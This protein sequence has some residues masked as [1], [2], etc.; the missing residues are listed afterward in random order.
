MKKILLFAAAMLAFAGCKEDTVTPEPEPD[1]IS[2]APE[3]KDFGSAGGKVSVV[4]TS[5]GEWTLETEDNA[6][7]NW[8]TADKPS[9]VDGDVVKFEVGRNTDADAGV[10]TAKFIFVCGEATA[11]FTITSTPE[12]IVVPELTIAVTSETPVE[13][14]YEAGKF[15]V[16]LAISE[17]I[18]YHDLQV[19]INQDGEWLSHVMTLD[20]DEDNTAKMDFSYA[21]LDGLDSREAEITISY[22]GAE[23][24]TVE[25]LQLPEPVLRVDKDRQVLEV[26]EGTFSVTVET[27]V[28]YA[29]TLSEG[30]EEW[31]KDQKNEG[32]VWS[33]SH[34]AWT[35]QGK[36]EA[37][38]TFTQTDVAEG[39]EPLVATVKVVQSNYIINVAAYMKMHCAGAPESGWVKPD[40][41]KF[42]D[43]TMTVEMLVNLDSVYD[44]E[45]GT[46]FGIERR[47][48]IRHGDFAPK[49]TWELVYVT[50]QTNYQGENQE[51]KLTGAA[52]PTDKWA[53]IAVV[54]DGT[55]KT[56]TLYQDGEQIAT[57]AMN[58]DIKTIDLTETYKNNQGT[59]QFYLGRAYDNSRDFCGKMSEVRIWNKALTSEEIK[60]ANHFYT[61][62]ADS[63]GLVAYWKLDDGTGYVIKDYTANGNNLEGLYLNGYQWEPGMEWVDVELP[64]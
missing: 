8:V 6:V 45:V 18:D 46:L 39:A 25:V 50:N 9:G 40:V 2:V 10:K 15:T 37:T 54:L 42:A 52:L 58:S 27:N 62:P 44:Q 38:I 17:G 34:G 43:N 3:R 22:D 14:P 1:E 20:G 12:E 11:P 19:S 55:A 21:A 56:V 51:V 49:N 47:F 13:L 53:H 35:E 16:L 57:A 28:E 59:Q 29:V 41:L 33:W 61:V 60:A 64:E 30:A 36:R 31:I 5:S 7:Y 32:D 48:L 24:V 23:P 26:S 4:V 63:E